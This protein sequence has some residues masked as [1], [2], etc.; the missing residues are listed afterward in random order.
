M[1]DNHKINFQAISQCSNA[2]LKMLLFLDYFLHLT[3][4]LLIS[5]IL[6]RITK[7]GHSTLFEAFR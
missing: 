4:L 3:Y 7:K 1:E 6:L 2:I 5:F